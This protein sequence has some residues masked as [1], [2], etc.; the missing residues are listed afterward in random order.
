MTDHLSQSQIFYR[1]SL[2]QHYKRIRSEGSR[3]PLVSHRELCEEFGVDYRV[4]TNLMRF[5]GAPK[6]KYATGGKTTSRNTW[7]EAEPI[8]NW[9]KQYKEKQ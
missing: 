9:W 3:K 6:P 2:G 4:L 7:Y 5:N 8:R 1:E